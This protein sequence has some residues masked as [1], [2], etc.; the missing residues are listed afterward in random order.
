MYAYCNQLLDD[1]GNVISTHGS[2]WEACKAML[3]LPS[4][5]IAGSSTA[6]NP[7]A[8]AK[9][10]ATNPP[11]KDATIDHMQVNCVYAPAPSDLTPDEMNAW[12]Q[13]A[14]KLPS[15]F[16]DSL[17]A[18]LK[19]KL[20]GKPLV[21]QLYVTLDGLEIVQSWHTDVAI[22][23]S[24]ITTK[25]AKGEFHSYFKPIGSVSHASWVKS[26]VESK[27]Y[28][29]R[30]TGA[31]ITEWYADG[32]EY[33]SFVL[34]SHYK[35]YATVQFRQMATYAWRIDVKARLRIRA[36]KRVVIT[37]DNTGACTN[38]SSYGAPASTLPARKPKSVPQLPAMAGMAPLG[39]PPAKFT[40]TPERAKYRAACRKPFE[41]AVASVAVAEPC[42]V[43]TMENPVMAVQT[44]SNPFEGDTV[45]I[46][47]TPRTTP[48]KVTQSAPR[49][50]LACAAAVKGSEDTDK[51]PYIQ[52][53]EIVADLERLKDLRAKM[54]DA[55]N[56]Y[57][58][59]AG[60]LCAKVEPFRIAA[61]R[62]AGECL[63]SVKTAG[64]T[65]IT[66]HNWAKNLKASEEAHVREVFGT[67]AD[68]YLMSVY[69]VATDC[70]NVGDPELMLDLVSVG[71]RISV[72]VENAA[73]VPAELVER[74]KASGFEIT[75]TH[76]TAKTLHHD[77]T[78]QPAIQALADQCPELKPVQYFK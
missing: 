15:K 58:A 66:Y 67:L 5:T 69:E 31:P 74:L 37:R 19:A 26:P 38:V 47:N 17:I 4:A 48:V 56:D 41:D 1:Q 73:A 49:P 16:S 35:Y 2:H 8:Q 7:P 23:V 3:A 55:E 68:T 46:A 61:S 10:E 59:L 11:S 62:D 36:A 72:E 52:T 29:A 32:K 63:G 39:I 22:N 50:A 45:K 76:K 6:E 43:A 40:T 78:M 53:P 42:T 12:E 60:Q 13:F 65:Y 77:R 24:G 44:R 27:D 18:S 9:W 64:G 75:A 34:T 51:A 70:S 71:A 14:D 20:A 57:N 25:D 33:D 54:K 28:T 30:D 21:S